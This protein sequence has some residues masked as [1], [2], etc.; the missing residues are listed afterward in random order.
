[1]R[2]IPKW[3]IIAFFDIF[4]SI[5]FFNNHH[6]LPKIF[7]KQKFRFI[8]S[9]LSRDKV[10]FRFFGCSGKPL[11]VVFKRGRVT[12]CQSDHKKCRS[13]KE[14]W[15]FLKSE[16]HF[17]EIF[18]RRPWRVWTSVWD[19]V[20]VFTFFLCWG[21]RKLRRSQRKSEIFVFRIR[22]SGLAKSK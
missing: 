21:F 16:K 5:F 18:S 19:S 12:T 17:Q 8:F 10:F 2:F 20:V 13:E 15:D 4:E 11:G 3:K 1:M 7:S 9:F 6:F 14:M 22:I